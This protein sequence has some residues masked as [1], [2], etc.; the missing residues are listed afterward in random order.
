M[1]NGGFQNHLHFLY[2]LPGGIIAKRDTSDILKAERKRRKSEEQ[3]LEEIVAAQLLQEQLEQVELSPDIEQ[4]TLR[5]VLQAKLYAEPAVGEVK[6][7]TRK[8]RIMLLLMM[9]E[10]DDD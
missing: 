2:G 7:A 3:R 4:N 10:L 9:L 8:K 5:D 1:T 6:G